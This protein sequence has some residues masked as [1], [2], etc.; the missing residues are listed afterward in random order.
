MNLLGGKTADW[1]NLLSSIV[2]TVQ[3]FFASQTLHNRKIIL[4]STYYKQVV[5]R[6]KEKPLYYYIQECLSVQNVKMIL[7]PC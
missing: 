3:S 1:M 6:L 5:K 2:C 7:Y 4:N